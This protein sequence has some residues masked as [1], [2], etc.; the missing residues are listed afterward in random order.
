MDVDQVGAIP[1]RRNGR[2]I[3]VLL[4]TTRSRGRWIVPKGNI[5]HD[6]GPRESAVME[7][8]EE[9][10]VEGVLQ[11]KPLGTYHHGDPPEYWVG[12]YLMEVEAT[13]DAWPEMD[14]RQR[15]WHPVSDAKQTVDEEGLRPLLDAARERIRQ[16]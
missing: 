14:E 11:G 8:Y 7:A 13:H 10:G 16:M 3:E 4:I 5:E 1:Y 12:I 2:Q 9:G 15:Q 6:L